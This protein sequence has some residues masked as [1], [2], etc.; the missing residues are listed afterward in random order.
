MGH[1][2]HG[3][4]QTADFAARHPRKTGKYDL[5][6]GGLPELDGIRHVP[7]EQGAFPADTCTHIIDIYS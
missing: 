1:A 4:R 7:N 6:R 2:T 3:I 5:P